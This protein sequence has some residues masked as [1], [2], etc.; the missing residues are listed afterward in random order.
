M[1][2]SSLRLGCAG[3]LL[4]AFTTLAKA[5]STPA[6]Q[7]AE[8]LA[9]AQSVDVKC[10]YLSAVEKDNLSRLV[11][12]AELA[13]ANRESVEAT[14]A[15][16]KRGHEAGATVTCSPDEKQA[17]SG[18][19]EAAHDAESRQGVAPPVKANAAVP[20]PAPQTSVAQAITQAPVQPLVKKPV[21]QEAATQ[22]K[23]EHM[24]KIVANTKPMKSSGS[25]QNYTR[26]T[27]EYFIARRCNSQN[28]GKL[29]QSI[30]AE[31]GRVMQD[32]SV[33]EVAAALHSGEAKARGMSCS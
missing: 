8:M 5:E 15:T 21:V 18:I 20:A 23:P 32:R 29:Y 4:A 13:L 3:L 25:L 1:L 6:E 14:K 12:R 28:L 30:V 33:D 17:M 26:L 19:L 16:L 22:P 11:A 24:T 9:R 27:Q 10:D 7:A 31:H 2:H